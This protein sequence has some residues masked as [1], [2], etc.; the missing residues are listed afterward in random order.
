MNR[1]QSLIVGV[2]FSAGS[3]T[4]LQQAI[5]IAQW[6]QSALHVKH[7]IASD[8]VAELETALGPSG[9][10]FLAGLRE[11]AQRSWD[12]LVSEIPAARSLTL[13]IEIGHPIVGLL[14]AV[15]DHS[16]DLLVLGVAGAGDEAR[17]A[18]TI[19]TACIRKARCPVLA[20][21]KGHTGSFRS[22][23]ACM[24]FSP[25]SRIALRQAVRVAAQDRAKL[26][27]LHVIHGPWNRLHYRAPTPQATPEFEKQFCDAL[28]RKMESEFASLGEETDSLRPEFHVFDHPNYGDGI[29]S[30][31]KLRDVDLVVLG[32]KGRTNLR[33]L[34]WG[35]TA[36]RVVRD[37][38]C[39]I[40]VVKPEETPDTPGDAVEAIGKPQIRAG[41]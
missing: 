22:V 16:A 21:R 26:H 13:E 30:F 39:S 36:E 32:T 15:V 38:P 14:Q 4:A 40:L 34:L 17:G 35:R 37:A 1:I 11:D 18:G 3:T 2:D 27:V 25:T 9:E 41:F 29:S 7:V 12:H 8:V 10:D 23:V 6:N 20:L 31:V 28:R 24:D 33:H 19:T 5:R